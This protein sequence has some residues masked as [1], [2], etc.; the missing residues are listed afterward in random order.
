MVTPFPPHP[1]P[2]SA[3]QTGSIFQFS[4]DLEVLVMTEITLS[5]VRH[6]EAEM[7]SSQET[8]SAYSD[9]G[10][11]QDSQA[12]LPYTD[13]VGFRIR[14]IRQWSLVHCTGIIN[15]MESDKKCFNPF[16]P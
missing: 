12:T 6:P 14:L 2:H 5:D 9:V 8:Q 1:H 7:D 10:D 3:K 11:S 15:S 13:E 16:G 4:D